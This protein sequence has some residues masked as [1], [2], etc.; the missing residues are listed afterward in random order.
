M[1]TPQVTSQL[2]LVPSLD[3]KSRMAN[4]GSFTGENDEFTGVTSHLIRVALA[5][6]SNSVYGSTAARLKLYNLLSRPSG[7][8]LEGQ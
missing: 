3:F 6:E 7:E 1:I 2:G 8:M 4:F 5:S